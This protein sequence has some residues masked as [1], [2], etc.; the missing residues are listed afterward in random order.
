ME[1]E[2]Y[3]EYHLPFAKTRLAGL[4]D[5]SDGKNNQSVGFLEDSNNRLISKFFPKFLKNMELKLK[6]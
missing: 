6:F 2:S 4:A 1:K 5:F 3:L